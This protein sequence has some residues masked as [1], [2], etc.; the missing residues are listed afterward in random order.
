M[1]EKL[2]HQ[3]FESGIT[4][5]V[6]SADHYEKEKFN[7]LR[8]G[9]N[10]EKIV[11]N[12][13]M[14]HYIR[15]KYYPDSITEI[16]VSG[17]DFH[18][19]LDR[20]KFADFWGKYSDNVSFSLP[21]ER[22]DTYNKKP[23]KDINSPCSNLWDRMYVWFDGVCNPCDADY[24]SYLSYGNVKDGSIK[25]IWNSS[26]LAEYR[27]KHLNKQRTSITPCDRCGIDFC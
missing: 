18:K 11:R 27:Q 26:K 25:K 22:G 21:V 3:N 12:V 23:D 6:I 24:K 1:D 5:L 7:I 8:K 9:A 2:C 13:T 15:E 16:R 19:N 10:F 20:Q 4:T 14:L 17:V